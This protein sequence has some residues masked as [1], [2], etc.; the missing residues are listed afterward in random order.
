MLESLDGFESDWT[1]KTTGA[2]G[3]DAILLFGKKHII[4]AVVERVEA[5]GWRLFD[6]SFS[7]L[8]AHLVIED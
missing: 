1:F 6:G 2:G 5:L 8:G 4:D 7:E 3:E